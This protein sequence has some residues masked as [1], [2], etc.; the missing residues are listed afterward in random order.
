VA[1]RRVKADVGPAAAT[2]AAR[3]PRRFKPGWKILSMI[4]VAALVWFG[5]PRF[6]RQL[7]FFR[8][9][10]I[11]FIGMRHLERG[12]AVAAL[13]LGP[14]ASVFDDVAPLERR[15][16]A[17]PGV[18]SVTIGRRLPGTLV[19]RLEEWTPVALAPAAK[20]L[21]F[22]DHTGRVLPFDPVESAPD[23]PVVPSPDRAV[24]RVLARVQAQEPA[25]FADVATAWRV[26]DDVV[27]VVRGRRIWLG[28]EASA[29][30]IRAVMAVAQDLTRQGREYSELD[31]RFA[32]Q[33]IVRGLQPA[34]PAAAAASEN[35][36]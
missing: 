14:Q 34:P 20:G 16:F 11:D 33:V 15:L 19:V 27:L 30:E 31:G 22:I 32:G 8:V 4:A 7:H 13:A 24:A 23:L 10:R 36:A 29:E 3:T 2:A 26:G 28:P 6:A 21:A 17:V 1:A 18:K 5:G 35:Q 12:R 25:L 9:R